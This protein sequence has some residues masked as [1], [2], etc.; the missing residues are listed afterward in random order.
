MSAAQE[1]LGLLFDAKPGPNYTA[2]AQPA[3]RTAPAQPLR[4]VRIQR[5]TVELPELGGAV[6]LCPRMGF[7]PVH[8]KHCGIERE[9]ERI[10]YKGKT[11][12]QP[13][14]CACMGTR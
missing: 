6:E 5:F 3:P 7:S 1:L 2:K 11:W 8:C 4:N 14:P 10:T 12:L 9:N 13:Q